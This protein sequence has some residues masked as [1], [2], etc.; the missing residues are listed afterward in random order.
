MVLFNLNSTAQRI[1]GGSSHSLA[2]CGSGY[3][4]TW[5]ANH[6]GELG[7]GETITTGC[8]CE[9]S[10]VDVITLGGI[11]AVSGGEGHSLALTSDSIVWAWGGNSSGQLGNGTTLNSSTPVQVSG[12][13][14]IV[15][16]SGGGMHSVALKHDGTV[17]AW[18]R[19]E[20]GELGNGA[21]VASST[22]V[23]VLG[24][25]N[26]VSIGAGRYHTLAVRNDGTVWAWGWNAWGQLGDGSIAAG[27]CLCETLAVQVGGLADI[28][29]VSGGAEHSLGLM[30]NGTVW[31][32]GENA[33]GQ[34]G[35][36]TTIT[37]GCH[38]NPNP[39][40]VSGLTNI[41]AISGAA[42]H[43]VAMST[44]G[45]VWSWGRNIEGE[46]GN[47]TTSLSSNL[48]V[49]VSG[50]TNVVAI[51]GSNYATHAVKEDGTVWGWGRNN[52]AQL[53]DGTT[54]D[55]PAPVQ[56]NGLCSIWVG[57]DESDDHTS[58]AVYPNPTSGE[59]VVEGRDG[60]RFTG[61]DIRN[62]LGQYVHSSSLIVSKL[63]IDL[64]E[65]PSGVYMLVIKVANGQALSRRLMKE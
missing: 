16:I 51:A 19:N 26:M 54:S 8:F 22:P 53:G 2:L 42:A 33:W 32:W 9:T 13:S 3:A 39:V 56:M 49:Q 31:A 11:T 21:L 10:P 18:G 64:S 61:C 34:L 29:A 36:G 63:D 27:G 60:L 47:G 41:T 20:R 58:V 57:L 62:A 4:M 28:V 55:R 50:L 45:T 43:S 40:Q 35:D 25:T 17:W 5:G 7:N 23:Q 1:S 52:F 14:G 46:L 6:D 38:C 48:P 44:D 30:G 37:T 24:L 15:A 65:L 12:L 59:F